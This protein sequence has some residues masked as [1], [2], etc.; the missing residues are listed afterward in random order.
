MNDHRHK[1]CEVCHQTFSVDRRVGARQR[2]CGRLCCQQERKRRYLRQWL[3]DDPGYY[4][5]RYCEYLKTWL[6][7]H[8]GYLRRYRQA[9]RQCGKRSDSDIQAELSPCFGEATGRAAPSRDI[10]VEITFSI[11]IPRP[12]TGLSAGDIQVQSSR[13]CLKT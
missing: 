6:A 10:Q 9:K 13:C 3:A 11:S 5:R 8:P 12:N 2:V 1:T 7:T 4:Q